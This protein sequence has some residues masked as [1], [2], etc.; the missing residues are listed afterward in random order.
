M[1]AR[2]DIEV[3]EPDMGQLRERVELT[4]VTSVDMVPA[5]SFSDASLCS[6][7]RVA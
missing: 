3:A 4:R 7:G 2:N 1:S 6:S 5:R